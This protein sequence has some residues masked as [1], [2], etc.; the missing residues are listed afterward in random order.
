MLKATKKK[1]QP[2]RN[3]GKLIS[4]RRVPA[5]SNI[6]DATRKFCKIIANPLDI[7]AKP[8]YNIIETENNFR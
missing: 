5:A 8:R 4:S 6:L 1:N 2:N 7:A 3:A